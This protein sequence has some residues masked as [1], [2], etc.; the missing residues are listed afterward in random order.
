MTERRR[1]ALKEPSSAR[2]IKEPLS[3]WDLPV[4]T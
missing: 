3:K 1:L 4:Q 2:K